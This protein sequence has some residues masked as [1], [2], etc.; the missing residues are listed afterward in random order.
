MRAAFFDLDLTLLAVN[1]G[2]LWLERERRLGHIS[3]WHLLQGLFYLAAYKLHT[4][5]MERLYLKA[6]TF[7]KD[8]SEETLRGCVHQWFAQEV[9]PHEAPGARAVLDRHRGDGDLLVLLTSATNYEAEVAAAHFGLDAYLATRYEVRDGAF[10]GDVVR[11]VCFGEGKVWHAERLAE[12]RGL[13]LAQ[14][15]FYTD[16]YTDLP[17]LLRVGHPF[18]VHPDPRLRREARAR[19]WPVLDWRQ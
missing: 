14:S 8:E 18:A 12:A 9:A 16:S 2:R 11:P 19:G 7:A 13:D 3:V 1:S 17:M 6:M 5:D 4:V 10:T 15:A